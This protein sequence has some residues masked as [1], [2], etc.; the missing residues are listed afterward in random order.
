MD[1]VQDHRPGGTAQ[2]MTL[3]DAQQKIESLKSDIKFFQELWGKEKYDH[4]KTRFWRKLYARVLV[5]VSVLAV[6]G[7]LLIGAIVFHPDGGFADIWGWFKFMWQ[8][9]VGWL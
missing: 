8:W 3:S 6:P 2:G 9:Y 5:V 7:W 4:R 1:D